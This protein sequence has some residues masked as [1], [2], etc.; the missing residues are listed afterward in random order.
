M[1]LHVLKSK[2]SL[3]FE[4]CSPIRVL[5]RAKMK[6]KKFDMTYQSLDNDGLLSFISIKGIKAH[7]SKLLIKTFIS[8]CCYSL[9]VSFTSLITT[10]LTVQEPN[11]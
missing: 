5:L 8:H 1:E 9:R 3:V 11:H 2:R 10:R 6:M 4:I 7:L